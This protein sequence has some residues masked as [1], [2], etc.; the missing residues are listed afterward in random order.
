MDS[1]PY[2][3]FTAIFRPDDHSDALSSRLYRTITGLGLIILSIVFYR[4][5]G[6]KL[7]AD[8]LAITAA[9]ICGT[10]MVIGAVKGVIRGKLNVAE[11][12]TLAI[13]GSFALGEYLVAAEV[14]FIMTAGGYLEERVV[15]R[16]KKEIHELF[17][18]IPQNARLKIINE[19]KMVS[20]A[21]IKPGD[22]VMVKPGEEIPVDGI[23]DSGSSL[24]SEANITGES[25]PRSKRPGDSVYAG[26]ISLDG[27]LTVKTRRTGGQS[28]LGRMVQLTNQALEEKTPTVRLA[29]RFAAWFTPFVLSLT[30]IV[31]VLSGDPVRAITVLVVMCPCTLVLAI[32]TALAASLG[33]AVRNGILPK[34]GIYLEKAAEIDT[35]ILDKTGTLTFGK[36]GISRVMPL[37]G[38]TREYL[39]AMAATAE[40]YSIHPIARAIVEEAGRN[41]IA[42]P[43]PEEVSVVP[44][45][46]VVAKH[47]GAEIVVSSAGF[48]E[49]AGYRNLDEALRL[50]GEE[51][52]QGK[53]T[54]VIAVNEELKGV[55]SLEDTLREETR[56]S[57]SLLK[58]MV[59][60]L[61]MLTGDNYSTAHQTAR[62]TG[63][64]EFKARLLP[65]DKVHILKELMAQGR[66]VAAVGDGVNDAPLL[67]AA[68]VGIAMGDSP[69]SITLDAGSVVLMNGDF[70]KL[71]LF[72]KIARETRSIIKQNIII[73]AVIYNLAAFFLAF[74]GYL[75]PLGGAIVHNVGST[76]VVLNSMRLMR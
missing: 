1:F 52:N 51:E 2:R 20:L 36:P 75:S 18:L 10:E 23:I 54:F 47:R 46:G 11:L 39:L 30:F 72:F 49:E 8:L 48:A 29:D 41:N 5:P 22:L 14:A 43:D 60:R 58:G 16:S 7:P 17:S 6:T 69:A 27:A 4:F 33:K 13:M 45:K 31:Y 34:G 57:M 62:E 74:S 70:S 15:D 40:K 59:P 61:I 12:V 55:I 71:P 3:S 44:G 9:V 67:A 65:E 64:S 25:A 73:F 21:E 42:I 24:V 50:V 63:I 19:E 53:S 26:S 32:P 76:L 35:V 68:D 66:R 28:T 56:Q 38:V 37:E